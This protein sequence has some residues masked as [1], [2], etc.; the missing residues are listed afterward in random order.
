LALSRATLQAIASISPALS[1]AAEE[2]L[3]HELELAARQDAPQRVV[4]TIQAAQARLQDIPDQVEMMSALERA[5][6]AAADA[7]PDIKDLEAAAEA[8]VRAQ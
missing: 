2:A 4:E 1:A 8:A 7:L 5:L 6:L 3:D